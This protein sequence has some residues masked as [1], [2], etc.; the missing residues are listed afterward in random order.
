MVCLKLTVT[1]TKGSCRLRCLRRRSHRAANAKAVQCCL[2]TRRVQVCCGA[3]A[4]GTPTSEARQSGGTDAFASQSCGAKH[5][6]RAL[7]RV[8]AAML[9]RIEDS[10][11]ISIVDQKPQPLRGSPSFGLGATRRASR[12]RSFRVRLRAI[13]AYALCR[14][15]IFDCQRQSDVAKPRRI[16]E[17]DCRRVF[18][19]PGL[20]SMSTPGR[21]ERI[22]E[23]ELPSP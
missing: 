2:R 12:R 20:A 11:R 4:Y 13:C 16:P 22:T 6:C 7:S 15:T 10:R 1:I 23:A 9:G 14:P 8:T 19:P 21:P 5:Q 3:N 17:G 18:D